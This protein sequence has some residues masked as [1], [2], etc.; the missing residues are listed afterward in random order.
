MSAF[1]LLLLPGLLCDRELWAAQVEA[2][3]GR[4][5]LRIAD[6]TQD[7][8]VGAMAARA[9]AGMPPRFAVAALSMGGY[10]A[11]ELMRAVPE[12]VAALCLF[13]TSARPDTKEQARRRRGLIALTRVGRFRGVN[14]RLLPE[15][16]HPDNLGNPKLRD[17][18]TGMALRVGRDAFIR[19][20]TAILGRPDSRPVLTR[21]AVPTLVCTGEADR[22]IPP[23]HAAEIAAGIRGAQ[24]AVIA[25]SG[26]LPP[27]ERPADVN[28]LLA[29]WMENAVVSR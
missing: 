4:Y 25:G 14:P 8:S 19:Q 28:R 1:P 11:F 21:I 24:F 22:F 2:L 7:D 5:D 3:S 26:H 29:E 16:L 13:D 27:L 9:I 23:E 15:L 10:V 20:Q 17:I 12:R 18:V 6:L